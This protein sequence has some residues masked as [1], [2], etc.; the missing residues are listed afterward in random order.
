MI[1][2]LHTVFVTFNILMFTY[3]VALNVNYTG[4][5]LLGRNGIASY[6]RRR[7]LRDYDTIVDSELSLGVTVLVPAFNEEPVVAESVRALLG[8]SY[9]N[10]EV[11]VINDGSTD[12]TLSLI[13]I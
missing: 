2:T 9:R 4:L 13:H 12:G 8:I 3:F 10:C 11:V 7:A 5:L 1:D 6:V